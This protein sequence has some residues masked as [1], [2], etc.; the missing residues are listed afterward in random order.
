MC[1]CERE[2]AGDSNRESG[3]GDKEHQTVCMSCVVV[4]TEV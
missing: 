4:L 1:V 3:G 2:S